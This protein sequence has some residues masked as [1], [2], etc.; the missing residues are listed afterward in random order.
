MLIHAI[1]SDYDRTLACE[2]VV[3]QPTLAALRRVRASGRKLILVT[4]RELDSLRSVFTQLDLFDRIVAENGALLFNPVTGDESLLATGAFAEIL[5]HLRGLGI[6]VSVGRSIVATSDT[7]HAA[8]VRGIAEMN[9]PLD[10]IL[11]Q[12]SVM[13]LPRGINKETGLSVALGQLKIAPE[14]VVAIGDAEND[15]EFLSFCGCSVAVAN[16]IPALKREANIVTKESCGAGVVEVI[17]RLLET[18]SLCEAA[19][20]GN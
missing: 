8:V 10:V 3:D 16:A 5:A 19:D 6:P 15:F 14:N 4:G 12:D 17:D 7:Y 13:I 1:A 11:N 9:A 2:G 20:L 18:G